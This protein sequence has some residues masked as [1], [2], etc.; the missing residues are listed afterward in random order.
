MRVKVYPGFFCDLDA[1]DEDGFM[2]VGYP[3]Y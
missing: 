2:Y 3:L 1:L